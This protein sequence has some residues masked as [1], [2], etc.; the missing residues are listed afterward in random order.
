MSHLCTYNPPPLPPSFPATHP[1]ETNTLGLSPTTRFRPEIPHAPGNPRPTP[2]LAPPLSYHPPPTIASPTSFTKPHRSSPSAQ[3]GQP[4]AHRLISPPYILICPPG[5]AATYSSTPFALRS[6]LSGLGSIRPAVGPDLCYTSAI[7]CYRTS[8]SVR[9]PRHA[10]RLTPP[11]RP[12]APQSH[13]SARNAHATTCSQRHAPSRPQLAADR[14]RISP[15]R[16]FTD[17]DLPRRMN[18]GHATST[19]FEDPA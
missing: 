7:D 4:S 14:L 17:F 10:T 12:V 6:P 5:P 19:V 13:A 1:S 3:R 9:H 8:Y 11:I 18:H 2:D 15:T 16:R